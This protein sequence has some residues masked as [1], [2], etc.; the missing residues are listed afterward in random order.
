M[1]VVSVILGPEQ[2]GPKIVHKTLP[3]WPVGACW[4]GNERNYQGGSE[5]AKY[6]TDV[7]GLFIW[8]FFQKTVVQS[9]GLTKMASNQVVNFADVDLL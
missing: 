8:N 7:F 2:E 5:A 6:V 1:L 9:G 3:Y 4:V